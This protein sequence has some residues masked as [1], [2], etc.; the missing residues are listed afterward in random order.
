M[1]L[2]LLVLITA[3][4]LYIMYY[5]IIPFIGVTLILHNAFKNKYWTDCRIYNGEIK[6]EYRKKDE[7]I[8]LIRHY[9]TD[10]LRFFFANMRDEL[11]N[12]YKTIQREMT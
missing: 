5:Y 3:I 9:N 12:V 2:V 8:T 7:K 11:N 1:K 10:T 4:V 6:I